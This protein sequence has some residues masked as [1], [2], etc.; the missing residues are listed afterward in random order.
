MLGV[1][2]CQTE[3]GLEHRGL[4]LG[5]FQCGILNAYVL[6]DTEYMHC[7]LM[8]FNCLEGSQ[9]CNLVWSKN[10]NELV[11][12]H[13]YSQNQIVVWK[14]P[15]MNK[16]TTLVGHNTRVLYLAQSPDGQT[17]VTGA[18]KSSQHISKED[19]AFCSGLYSFFHAVNVCLVQPT[20][21]HS[22]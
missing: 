18:G 2:K 10:V 11:S 5:G 15:S 6:P 1:N 16:I 22:G 8:W 19:C 9:V 21:N 13:G 7:T 12:T 17:V 20:C 3:C 4:T 14:Y